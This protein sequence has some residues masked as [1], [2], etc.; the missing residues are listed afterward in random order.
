MKFARLSALSAAMVLASA[1]QANNLAPLI[2]DGSLDLHLR[3]YFKK[4]TNKTDAAD[5]SGNQWAQ[6]FSLNYTSGYFADIIGFDVGGHYALKLKSSLDNGI[7]NPGLLKVKDGNKSSSFGKA[8]YAVKVNLMDY[9]VAKYGRMFLDTPLL[10]D[11]Y[12]RTLPSLTEGFY[13]DGTFGD[14]SLYGIWAL[15]ANH[16]SDTGFND[17]MVQGSKEAVKVLGGGYNF[18]NGLNGLDTNLALAQQDEYARRYYI[19]VGY[20]FD[21]DQATLSSEFIYGRNTVIGK[22]K[23]NTVGDK[24]QNTWSLAVAAEAYNATLGVSYQS[25]SKSDLGSYNTQ[26]S[27]APDTDGDMTGYFGPHDMMIGNFAGN[28]QKSWGIN[29][30]YDFADVVDGLSV[31]AAYI[32]GDTAP[33]TESADDA[34]KEESEYNVS[35]SYAVPQVENLNISALYAKNTSKNKTEDSKTTK[36]QIRLIVKYDMSVF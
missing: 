27:G 22:T 29:A 24:S 2:E 14:A 28:G 32:K 21:V 11:N 7:G 3:N 4:D 25:V 16:R 10:E 13:A 6:A 5:L 31:A 9:G 35:V 34:K 30:G 17:L 1:A 15:K 33:K 18:R 36:S 23:T 19:D 12:S 26:W 20:T 8:S